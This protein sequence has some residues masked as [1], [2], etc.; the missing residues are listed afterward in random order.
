M[1]LR[2]LNGELMRGKLTTEYPLSTDGSP[3]LV[4]NGEPYGPEDADFGAST[5]K[6]KVLWMRILRM[7][8]IWVRK[9]ETMIR[10]IGSS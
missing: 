8:R 7:R 6:I 5:G 10:T 9:W 2:N 4:V 1:R 3:V